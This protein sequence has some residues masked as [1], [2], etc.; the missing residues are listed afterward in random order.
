METVVQA[1]LIASAVTLV[2][3]L[4]SQWYSG[5]AAQRRELLDRRRA[6]FRGILG[7]V[8]SELANHLH[9]LMAQVHI[10][11]HKNGNQA[12]FDRAMEAG[13]EVERLRREQI[14]LLEDLEAPLRLLSR[15]PVWV[16]HARGAEGPQAA[17]LVSR[18]NALKDE[19]MAY[20]RDA[21]I[22]GEP[23]ASRRAQLSAL[24]H[25][26]AAYYQQHRPVSDTEESTNEALD[27]TP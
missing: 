15:V 23:S 21:L 19:V 9:C 4:L 2:G 7:D 8:P 16:H 6:A 24:S 11:V 25:E 3:N 26:L 12:H 14:L 18:A 10:W 13:R 1:A 17:E 5:R 27:L 22:E 20:L